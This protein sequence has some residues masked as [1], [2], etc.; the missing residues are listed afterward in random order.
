MTGVLLRLL[1]NGDLLA[2]ELRLEHRL[3]VAPVLARELRGLEVAGEARSPGARARAPSPSRRS[4]RPP[5][6]LGLRV[7]VLRGRASRARACRPWRAR[8]RGSRPARTKRPRAAVDVCRIASSRST[9]GRAAR[10]S[11]RARGSTCGRSRSG[12]PSSGTNLV[13]SIE[14]ESS[15][16]SS[17]SRSA[18]STMTN[19]PFATSKPRTI[20]SC[21]TSRSWVG[22][23]RFCLIGVAHSVEEAERD[24]RLPGSR[25]RRGASP[26]GI[27]TRPK[28][29]DPFQVVRM[30][31]RG[32]RGTRRFRHPGA[33][34]SQ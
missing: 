33:N 26:T 2:A 25:L 4:P 16:R 13:I 27:E 18:S 20:S 14:R 15:E 30:G 24:V 5:R 17:A 22:H 10:R 11:R 1:R 9:Y 28:L 32:I 23:Q 3:Q 6:D 7:Y 29:R 21:A 12:R 34:P 19:W 31:S 8:G